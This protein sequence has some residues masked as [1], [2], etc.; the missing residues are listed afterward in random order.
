MGK[1]ILISSFMRIAPLII[2]TL[3]KSL[4]VKAL[5]AMVFTMVWRGM[6]SVVSMS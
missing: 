6:S 1:L 5:K 3:V 2:R 4:N